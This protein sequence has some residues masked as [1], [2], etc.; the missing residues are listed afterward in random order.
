MDLQVPLQATFKPDQGGAWELK[1]PFARRH[2]GHT[3]FQMFPEHT[4]FP[5]GESYISQHLHVLRRV[6]KDSQTGVKVS[7]F[8]M[9]ENSFFD[10]KKNA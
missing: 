6:G 10:F 1:P 3:A 2:R 4:S 5:E 9:V 7:A 8:K